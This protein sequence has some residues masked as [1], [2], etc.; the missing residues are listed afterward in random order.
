MKKQTVDNINPP[1]FCNERWHGGY[2]WQAMLAT[3]PRSYLQ[4]NDL[5]MSTT[6]SGKR[7][8]PYN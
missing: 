8:M 6:D 3:E 5:F 7:T 1:Q 2:N 4:A